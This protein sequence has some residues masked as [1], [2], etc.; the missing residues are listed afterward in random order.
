MQHVVFQVADPGLDHG[1][2]AIFLIVHVAIFTDS[3]KPRNT[4]LRAIQCER[5][6]LQL[7]EAVTFGVVLNH[8]QCNRVKQV[9]KL[10]TL[11]PQRIESSEMAFFAMYSSTEQ[12]IVVCQEYDMHFCFFFLSDR[13][14]A[15][16]TLLKNP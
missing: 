14:S 4:A 3:T 6:D 2:G 13:N 5:R 12:T 9:K 1:Q 8:K 15:N 10:D 11:R 16:L 7:V